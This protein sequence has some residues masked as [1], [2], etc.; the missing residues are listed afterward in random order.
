[1]NQT[2]NRRGGSR[3]NRSSQPNV[4]LKRIIRTEIKNIE[5]QEIETKIIDIFGAGAVSTTPTLTVLTPIAHGTGNG[6]RV[7]DSIIITGLDIDISSNYPFSSSVF[8]QDYWV[9]LRF[10]LFKWKVSTQLAVPTYPVIIQSI[11]SYGTLSPF[12]WEDRSNY[13]VI[14]DYK[15]YLTGFFNSSTSNTVPTDSS[16]NKRRWSLRNLNNKIIFDATSS[17][18]NHFY[19]LIYSDSGTTPHPN[20]QTMVRVY[21][22]DS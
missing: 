1:M 5:K 18:I 14:I 7:G 9:N 22:T 12:N 11:S 16:V 2:G 4:N 15:F 6:Q 20:V 21:Y 3:R 13:K 8:T 10:V 19:T 17:G